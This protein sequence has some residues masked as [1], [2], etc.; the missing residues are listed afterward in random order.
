VFPYTTLFLSSFFYNII[1]ILSILIYVFDYI[2]S[3]TYTEDNK[4][5]SRAHRPPGFQE[6]EK[7]HNGY[8]YNRLPPGKRFH[9]RKRCSGR[10]LLRSAVSPRRG[11]LSYYRP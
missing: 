10:R 6:K 11:E 4:K 8:T 5:D 1:I 9:R 7:E 3:C 2:I